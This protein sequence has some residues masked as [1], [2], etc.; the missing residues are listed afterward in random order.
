MAINKKDVIQLLERIAIYLELKGENPFKIS[1]YRKAA[2]GLEQDD[3]SLADIEDF[4][5]IKGIGKGT[6]NVIVEFI[7]QG[8]SQALKEL[9]E[10]VPPGLIPLLNLPGLGGKKLSKLYQELGVIDA[11]T[12]KEACLSGK[13]ENLAGFGKKSAEKIVAALEESGKRPER[14]P[15]AIML[16]LAERIEAYLTEIEEIES[17]SRAGSLRRMRETIKDLDFIIA[18]SN[19]SAVREALLVIPNLKEVIAKG[20]TKVSV[21]LEDVY[22]INVDFRLVSKTEFATTLHHF[23]GSKD[24]NVALRQLAKSRGEKISEYGVEVEETNEVRT[25]S[26]EA[27]FFRYFGLQF[28][29]PEVRENTGEVEAF[30]EEKRLIELADIKGDL[31]MHT[32]WSDGAQSLE[33]MASHVRAMGYAYMAITDHSKYLRVANG[34]DE[35]RLRKQREEIA[36]LNEKWTD[37]HIFAGVEMDILPD[38]SLD[39]S[40]AFLREMDYVIGAIHSSFNQSQEKIMKRLYSALENPYVSLIAHP[41]G[42]LIGRRAGYNVNV[43]KLIEKAKETNTALEINANPNR[44]DLSADWVRKAQ[45]TGVTIAINTDAHSYQMLDHMAYGVGV[46]RRGWLEKDTVM[47]TWSKKKLMDYFNRNK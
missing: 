43:E 28:I 5:K 42:R 30:K 9:A 38:G 12:L 47:N 45:E 3:R 15:I 20:D 23:T 36:A 14:L 41:T 39:F 26:N 46:A 6:S 16:P 7:E 24:H 4:T 32:T 44:L 19:P 2:Q 37:F 10:Q 17:F 27:E 34:L 25:F 1:A 22:D 11:D 21:T 31:H 33:E 29:P 13:V 40:D 35:S 8:E 18:T